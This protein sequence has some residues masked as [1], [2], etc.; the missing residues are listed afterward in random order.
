MS[1]DV[2]SV[3]VFRDVAPFL[4]ALDKQAAFYAERH[5]DMLK[6]GISVPGL[7]MKYLFQDL[8]RD[9]YFT[10]YDAKNEDLHHLVKDNIVGGPSI[11]F[12]RY[13]EKD[14]TKLREVD[15]KDEAELCKNVTGFDA[16]ALY[17]WCLMQDMPTGWYVRRR[18]DNEFRPETSHRQSRVAVEWLE[19]TMV[20]ERIDIRHAFNGKEKK[21]GR[22]QLAVDGWC[23]DRQTVYQFHG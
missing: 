13:H 10:L 2:S 5:I 7:T 4:E 1:N 11:I 20:T 3:F 14:K 22:R 21:L 6:D 19:W 16:N 9:T 12:H 18:A 8:P 15:Y 17:L 23:K